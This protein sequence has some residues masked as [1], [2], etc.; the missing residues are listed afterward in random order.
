MVLRHTLLPLGR[1]EIHFPWGY[2]I[3][4]SLAPLQKLTLRRENGIV[5]VN[6]VRKAGLCPGLYK[7]LMLSIYNVPGINARAF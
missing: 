5:S 7:E 6:P 3:S 2:M 4:W 1:Q